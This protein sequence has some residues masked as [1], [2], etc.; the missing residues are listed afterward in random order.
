[1]PRY[2]PFIIALVTL[3]SLVLAFTSQYSCRTESFDQQDAPALTPEPLRQR[4]QD[5]LYKNENR[6]SGWSALTAHA[7]SERDVGGK[8]SLRLA[9]FPFPQGGSLW[10]DRTPEI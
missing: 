3:V 5:S 4:I 7:L 2:T 9:P 6:A 8:S 1:M 10:D